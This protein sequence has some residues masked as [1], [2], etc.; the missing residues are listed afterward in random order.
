[1]GIVGNGSPVAVG[2][3]VVRLRRVENGHSDVLPAGT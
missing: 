3:L 1:M 2:R